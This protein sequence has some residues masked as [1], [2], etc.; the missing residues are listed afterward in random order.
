MKDFSQ[1]IL[2]SMSRLAFNPGQLA[3]HLKQPVANL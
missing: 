3:R 2:Q 1:F